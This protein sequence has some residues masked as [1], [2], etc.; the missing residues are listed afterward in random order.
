[1]V[2][3]GAA[4]R[5]PASF[6]QLRGSN[7][8]ASQAQEVRAKVLQL[9]SDAAS[10]L[11]SPVLSVAAL[12]VKTSKDHF[13]KVRVIIKDIIDKLEDQAK[14]EATTKSFC[15]TEMA[16]AVKKRDEKKEELENLGATMSS[17]E[18]EKSV[19]KKEIAALSA[20]IAENEKALKEATELRQLEK[21]DNVKTMGEAKVGK[22]AVEF[23]LKT[24]KDF[25][26]KGALVQKRTSYVPPDSDRSGKTVE[27]LAPE[28]FD[29]SEYKGR[30][31]NSKGIVGLLEVILSDFD[32]TGNTVDANERMSAQE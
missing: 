15:D 8:H 17:K 25:Y 31:D 4:A 22:D 24:L 19:L 14:N 23:A 3:G 5:G 6:L 16:A 1:M 20:A 9:L 10:N 21:A 12:K 2:R 7:R 26:D 11:A 29:S 30:Q 28:G 32:R 13:A 27:D 18:A